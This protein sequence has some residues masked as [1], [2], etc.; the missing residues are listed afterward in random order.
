MG[1]TLLYPQEAEAI[2]T[3]ADQEGAG[4]LMFTFT[5]Q[6][7]G[8]LFS[9]HNAAEVLRDLEEAGAAAVGFNC[10]SADMMTPYLVAKL[11]RTLRGPLICKPNAGMPVINGQGVAEYKMSPEEFAAVMADCAKSGATVLGGCCGTTPGHIA[12][13]VKALG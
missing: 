13:M 3:A 2:L 5:M 10:V 7:D 8:T 1:E 12:A 11:R 4:A 9:G 6:P